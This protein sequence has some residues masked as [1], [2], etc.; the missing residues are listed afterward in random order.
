MRSARIRTAWKNKG[1]AV[2]VEEHAAA[3]AAVAWRVS[4]NA[5]KNL[6][7]QAFVYENDAQRLGVICEYLY[8]FIHAADRCVAGRFND[9]RRARFITRLSHECRRHYLENQREV[10]AGEPHP[11]R[12]VDELNARM[13][14]YA[15]T[16]FDGDAPGY[17]T[18]RA[19]GLWVEDCLGRDQPNKWAQDQ[20]INID[21][22]EAFGIFKSALSALNRAADCGEIS[23]LVPKTPTSKTR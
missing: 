10:M 15:G 9:H 4:L 19:L 8:F 21:G 13:A 3:V 5:A 7:Q 12:F 1:R 6:H 22:P 20:V 11:E 16:R 14:R 17:E 23:G 2:S 18:L